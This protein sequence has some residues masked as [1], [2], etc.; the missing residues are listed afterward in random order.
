MI[1]PRY[2]W[3]NR[4]P[5]YMNYSLSSSTNLHITTGAAHRHKTRACGNAKDIKMLTIESCAFEESNGRREIDVAELRHATLQFVVCTDLG[6]F[7]LCMV[8]LA[9]LDSQAQNDETSIVVRSHV[10]YLFFPWLFAD[11][12]ESENSLLF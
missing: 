5:F 3:V 10:F 12:V 7:C 11:R 2:Q 1:I 8:V 4:D 9:S 6:L